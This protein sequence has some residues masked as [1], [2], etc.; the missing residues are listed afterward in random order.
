[1]PT[2]T[3]HC[4]T[5][6]IVYL[7]HSPESG[8]EYRMY[9]DEDLQAVYGVHAVEHSLEQESY[10]FA[11]LG[12]IRGEMSLRGR[13]TVHNSEL[14][15]LPVLAESPWHIGRRNP[16]F[17]K[18]ELEWHVFRAAFEATQRMLDG[19]KLQEDGTV[20]AYALKAL[21]IS[22]ERLESVTRGLYNLDKIHEVAEITVIKYWYDPSWPEPHLPYD[23]SLAEYSF[24]VPLEFSRT[25][26]SKLISVEVMTMA[27]C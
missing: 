1:M 10:W 11:R 6:V 12:L 15:K 22:P 17:G 7:V 21:K 20:D 24:H 16:A 8:P 27:L 18:S 2:Q 3:N 25:D 14:A 13:L 26:E 4:G 9:C 5:D 19:W 23:L